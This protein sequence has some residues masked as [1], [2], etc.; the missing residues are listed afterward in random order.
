[1]VQTINFFTTVELSLAL[2]LENVIHAAI[3]C[4]RNGAN[5][6]SAVKRLEHY[7]EK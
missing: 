5:L 4:K 1:M 3:A 7:D 2:G 6:V